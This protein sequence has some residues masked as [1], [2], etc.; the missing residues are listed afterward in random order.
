MNKEVVKSWEGETEVIINHA[1]Y[2][3]IV[4]TV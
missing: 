1:T 4:I 3:P 2:S